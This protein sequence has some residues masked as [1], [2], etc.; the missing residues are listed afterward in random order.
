MP[1]FPIVDAHVHLWDPR[2]F[3]MPWL[4][5]NALLNRPYG[6]ADYREHTDGIDIAAMVY[7]EVDVAPA[8]GL[9]EAR[10]AV[11]RAAEDA[12]LQGVVASAPL[13]DG[14]VARSYLAALVG[15]GPLIKGVR[16]LTQGE[17]DPDFARRPGFVRG[18]QILAEYG[19]SCDLG[20]R[21]VNLASTIALVG[22]CPD[23]R[24]ILDHLGKPNAREGILDPWRAQVREL[25]R[26]PNVFCKVSGLATEADRQRWTRDDLAPYV[27]HV[28]ECFGEDRV[29]FGG[30]WP[31]L[32]Q[33]S[34][35]PRWVQTLDELTG[36]MAES[37]RKKL[38]AE[39]ARTFYR[40]E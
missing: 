31:V 19:L 22:Q 24:F 2:R 33:A 13:E 26:F 4:D 28:I 11:D 39:N 27:G 38:W 37:A 6:L 5:G 34:T 9:L 7:L 23:T 16:R 20:I 15:L 3:R 32:T 10:W 12:R 8:Y 18:T 29:V 30:D 35:Y 14:E 36:G 17:P 21:H 25:A 1:E 40:L